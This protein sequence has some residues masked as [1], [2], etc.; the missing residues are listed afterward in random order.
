MGHG[1]QGLLL[2]RAL[3]ADSQGKRLLSPPYFKWRSLAMEGLREARASQAKKAAQY[4]EWQL[5]IIKA[6]REMFIISCIQSFIPK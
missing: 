3:R 6:F 4:E 2:L 5:E 1:T